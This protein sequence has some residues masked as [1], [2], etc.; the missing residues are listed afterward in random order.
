MGVK[1]HRL[2]SII[3]TCTVSSRN[4][5]ED[6]GILNDKVH[7][8]LEVIGPTA[9]ASSYG[10]RLLCDSSRKQHKYRKHSVVVD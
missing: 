10:Y 5:G 4:L 1:V 7:R 8:P 3:F 9:E 2:Y 6:E